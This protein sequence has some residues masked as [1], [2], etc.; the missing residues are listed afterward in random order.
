MRNNRGQVTMA[1]IVGLIIIFLGA[2]VLIVIGIVSTNINSA[3]D[4]DVDIGQV[5][6]ATVNA[7]TFGQFNTMVVNNADFWGMG[8]IIGMILG[9]WA[10]AYFTRNSFPTLGIIIDL[11]FIFLCFLV[12]LYIR[13]AYSDVVIALSGAGQSFAVDSLTNTNYFILNLPIFIAI[14]GVVAMIIFHMKLPPKAEELNI[15]T[16]GVGAV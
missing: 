7:Q 15:T 11:G 3:L 4:Q 8:L 1:L 2:L 13:A 12:S 9:I 14:I 10:G 5:N 16:G 6:L